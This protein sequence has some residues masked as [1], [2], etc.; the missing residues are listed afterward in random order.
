MFGWW[1]KEEDEG[2]DGRNWRITNVQRVKKG[3]DG[4]MEVENGEMVNVCKVKIER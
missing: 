3:D 1:R 2:V 4:Y